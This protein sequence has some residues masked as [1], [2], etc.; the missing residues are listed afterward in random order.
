MSNQPTSGDT[1]RTG[2]VFDLA[3]IRETTVF[4]GNVNGPV[5]QGPTS[6][7]FSV[8]T[9]EGTVRVTQVT[10]LFSNDALVGFRSQT[11]SVPMSQTLPGLVPAN[12]NPPAETETEDPVSSVEQAE[13]QGGPMGQNT[14]N[15]SLGNID[16]T[17]SATAV[18]VAAL[19]AEVGNATVGPQGQPSS[20]FARGSDPD[21]PGGGAGVSS[22]GPGSGPGG[23]TGEGNGVA[24]AP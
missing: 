11:F 10:P 18:A 9:Q 21:A 5:S 4:T 16:A 24:S 8:V 7:P 22:G 19:S 23:E 12:V 1:G 17:I 14:A 15:V 20:N 3:G 6:G 2:G 13:S